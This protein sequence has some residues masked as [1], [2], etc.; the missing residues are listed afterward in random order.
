LD[1]LQ[2]GQYQCVELLGRGGMAV[3]YKA[4]QPGL[5]RYVALKALLLDTG[6]R[7]GWRDRFH[8][9]AE[10]V[11][12]LEHPNILPTCDYGEADGLPYMVMQLV[13]GGTMREWLGKNPPMER[14]VTVF[15]QVLGALAHAQAIQ[16]R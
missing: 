7:D 4:L 6:Q 10:I 1:T 11:A 15:R 12:R 9:E 5:K 16:F 14:K 13:T 8:R 2:F 3:V